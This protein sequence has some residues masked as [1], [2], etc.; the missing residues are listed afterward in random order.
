MYIGDFIKEYREANGV[1]IEDF[2]NKA[3]LTVTEIEALEKNIQKDGTVVPVAMRQIKDIAAAMNVP[4]PV[5]MAQ[6]PSDQELVVHVVAESD[7]PH[8]K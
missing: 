4:M 8:A 5:V 6:I 2:A 3:S 7:Q 1:S